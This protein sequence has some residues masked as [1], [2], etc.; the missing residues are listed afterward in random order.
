M[1]YWL[2]GQVA[3][4]RTRLQVC[5]Q[6]APTSSVISPPVTSTLLG[7]PATLA[8]FTT[9]GAYGFPSAWKALTLGILLT[10]SFLSF[11]SQHKYHCP[12]PV[13]HLPQCQNLILL[14][15]I[16]F[17]YLV[18]SFLYLKVHGTRVLIWS[19]SSLCLTPKT[20]S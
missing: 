9:L 10:G 5:E 19:N 18:E 17:M 15:M 16:R 8:L 3:C 4:V 2:D 20:S 13:N 11:R 12:H 6:L 1:S 7:P 14:D